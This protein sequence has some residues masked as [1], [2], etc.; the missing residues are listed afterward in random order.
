MRFDLVGDPHVIAHDLPVAL[1]HG[2][3]APAI[4]SL[5]VLEDVNAVGVLADTGIGYARLLVP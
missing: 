5:D 4:I 3:E 1:H 2:G